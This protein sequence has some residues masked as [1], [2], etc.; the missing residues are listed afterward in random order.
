MLAMNKMKGK[1]FVKLPLAL[2]ARPGSKRKG[3]S[4]ETV[5][6]RPPSRFEREMTVRLFTV[7]FR[8][9]RRGQYR[10]QLTGGSR[11][12]GSPPGRRETGQVPLQN[13][14]RCGTVNPKLRLVCVK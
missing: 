12:T 14:N 5:K 4:R 2:S 11:H 1:A 6:L 10:E 3:A 13:K 7:E 9:S 8:S